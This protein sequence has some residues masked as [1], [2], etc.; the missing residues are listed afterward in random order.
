MTV[1]NEANKGDFAKTVLMPGDP[2]RAK[3][4]AERYLEDYKLVNTVRGMYA[5]TGFYKGVKVSV[6]ASGMGIPSIGIYSYEL[7]KFYD[8]ENIIRVGSCGSIDTNL[9][10][11]DIFVAK[12]AYTKSTYGKC[13]NIDEDILPSDAYISKLLQD[14]AFKMNKK[15]ALGRVFSSDTF[16]ADT[17][18]EYFHNEKGCHVV[19]MEAYALFCNAKLLNKKAAAIF[20]VSDS[21]ITKEETTAEERQN[22][23]DDMIVVALETAICL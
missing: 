5:Y 9:N 22:S 8:V 10:L 2:L 7:Y 21:I 4:I 13:F 11:Y 18:I 16:Y 20:T 3:M 15:I 6:M 1:H 12:D 14:T 23:F 17:D 19:E